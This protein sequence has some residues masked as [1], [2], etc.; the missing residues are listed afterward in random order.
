MFFE[1]CLFTFSIASVQLPIKPE[2]IIIANTFNVSAPAS[3]TIES[4]YIS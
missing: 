3:D 4:T 1:V 2:I